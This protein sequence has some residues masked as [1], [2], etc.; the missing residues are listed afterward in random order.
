MTCR[1]RKLRHTRESPRGRVGCSHSQGACE[2]FHLVVLSRQ[3]ILGHGISHV[4]TVPRARHGWSV[5]ALRSVLP[6]T[7]GPGCA[8]TAPWALARHGTTRAR[9][10]VAHAIRSRM[11]PR[12]YVMTDLSSGHNR[13]KKIFD[14]RYLGCHNFVLKKEILESQI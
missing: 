2:M 8:V 9:R 12:H 5:N 1:D 6:H 10:G 4:V 11:R 14:P 13:E 3:R 7:K